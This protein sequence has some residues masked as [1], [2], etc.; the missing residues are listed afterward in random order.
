MYEELLKVEV[1]CPVCG[2]V[3]RRNTKAKQKV[4]VC[5][6]CKTP[7]W[8]NKFKNQDDVLLN[9]GPV[10]LIAFKMFG[11]KKDFETM[12]LP[13]KN[14]LADMRAYGFIRQEVL[15]GSNS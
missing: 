4:V 10:D 11:G 15:N 8:M 3:Y 14:S 5:H 7:L 6:T 2:D 12:F 1:Q 13:N 9:F